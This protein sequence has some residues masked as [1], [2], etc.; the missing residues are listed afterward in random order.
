M[1]ANKVSWLI[2]VAL[3][4]YIFVVF[5]KDDGSGSNYVTKTYNDK[6][7][8]VEVKL[9]T[10]LEAGN[11]LEVTATVTYIGEKPITL[12]H[13]AQ[14]ILFRLEKDGEYIDGTVIPGIGLTSTFKPNHTETFKNGF[15][16]NEK[17]IYY[18]TVSSDVDNLYIDMEPIKI[19]V[20]E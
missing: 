13:G 6:Y 3:I 16:V 17:G 9:P 5:I 15:R 10:L 19:T 11:K 2:I 14:L 18:V 8:E 12:N 4:G 20:T 7:F 1:M